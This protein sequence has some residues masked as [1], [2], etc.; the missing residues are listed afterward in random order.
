MNNQYE[1]TTIADILELDQDQIERFCE[2]LPRIT[3]YM[4]AFVGLTDVVAD[5]LGVDS[6]QSMVS[7]LIW[8]DDGK[9]DIGITMVNDENGE[10][11]CELNVGSPNE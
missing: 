5:A 1:L 6:I 8:V 11:V 2:E 9:K 4:K 7:P 10:T 3:E